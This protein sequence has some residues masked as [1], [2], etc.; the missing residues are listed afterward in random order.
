MYNSKNRSTAHSILR[1]IRE[2]LGRDPLL[3]TI[4][5][6]LF[7]VLSAMEAVSVFSMIPIIELL[8][9]SSTTSKYTH[10]INEAF[11]FVN[12]EPSLKNYFIFFCVVIL[13]KAITRFLGKFFTLKTQVRFERHFSTLLMEELLLARGRFVEKY[14]HGHMTNLISNEVK[15]VGDCLYYLFDF[16]SVFLRFIFYGLVFIELSVE[17]TLVVAGLSVLLIV[18]SFLI[19]KRVHFYSKKRISLT[20]DLNEFVIQVFSNIL[21]IKAFVAEKFFSKKY[22][23][24]INDYTHVHSLVRLLSDL[25]SI[26][27]EPIGVLVVFV[28]VFLALNYFK[29]NFAEV[30]VVLYTLRTAIPLLNQMVGYFQVVISSTPSYDLISSIIEEA[31]ANQENYAGEELNCSVDCIEFSDVSFA[32]DKRMVI[33]QVSFSLNKGS[34]IALVGPSGSGKTTLLKLVMGFIPPTE[35]SILVNGKPLTELSVISWRN[36]IGL[37]SQNPILLRASLKENI[38]FG[39]GDNIEKDRLDSAV[40]F[41]DLS[42]VIKNLE[43]G[44]ETNVGIGGSGLSGGQGQRVAIA[45]ALYHNSDVMLLDEPTSSLDN[46]SEKLI[47]DTINHLRKNK[48]VILITHDLEL[49]KD[50]DQIYVMESGKI[51]ESGNYS[52]LIEKRDFFYRLKMNELER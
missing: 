12:F 13:A 3:S 21:Q 42:S 45:R 47:L 40:E 4:S 48:T 19:T 50:C 27:F 32:Y 24:K 1:L 18:P 38:A 15:K 9:D 30:L 26:V 10:M 44:L 14:S 20:S 22:V 52:A 6:T 36:H 34:F 29:M 28:V 46:H 25:T 43:N 35:G 31:G 49:V 2:V 41:S 51:V 7:I 16:V 37:V 23:Q 17:L 8:S 33:D 11:S 39:R 5:M